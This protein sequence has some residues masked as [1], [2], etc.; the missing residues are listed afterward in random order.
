M[1]MNEVD[2]D[3][4]LSEDESPPRPPRGTRVGREMHPE[5]GRDDSIPLLP[6]PNPTH[7]SG[8]RSAFITLILQMC[9]MVGS[10]RASDCLTPSFGR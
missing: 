8:L 7:N 6:Y 2:E 5:G 1:E 10:H 4:N 3:N 9:S